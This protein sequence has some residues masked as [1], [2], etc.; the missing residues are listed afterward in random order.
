MRNKFNNE[1]DIES[2]LNEE[3]NLFEKISSPS[4]EESEKRQMDE[5]KRPLKDVCK[6]YPYI[7]KE[8]YYRLKLY[9]MKN[10]ISMSSLITELITR[11]LD[12]HEG[13]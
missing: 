10:H 9:L 8:L 2:D 3:N 7:D 12:A 1:F 13:R 5:K 4:L 6:I 11:Y